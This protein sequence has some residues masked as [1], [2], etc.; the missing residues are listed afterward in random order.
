[1]DDQQRIYVSGLFILVTPNPNNPFLYE[2]RFAWRIHRYVRGGSDPNMPGCH[3]HRD[4]GY[5][6]EEG[7]GL[8]TAVNPEGLDWS[9][10]DGGA[11]FIADTGNN[12]GQRLSNPPSAQDYLILDGELGGL[13]SPVD[14][15][16]DLAGYS[17]VVDGLSNAVYRYVRAEVVGVSTGQ[18]VQRVDIEPSSGGAPLV[19]PVAVAADN[20]L[21]YVADGQTGEVAVF[22]RRR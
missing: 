9:P 6:V 12:R 3:W 7:S 16:A 22:R 1:V 10:A 20:D 8:G 15:C 4:T 5:A 19:E 18:L 14:V 17:Y 2:R 21:V 13:N 11:L